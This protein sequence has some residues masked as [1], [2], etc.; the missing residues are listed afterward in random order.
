MLLLVPILVAHDFRRQ[1]H[2]RLGPVRW[3]V[4]GQRAE[5]KIVLKH[6][7]RY[8]S[9]LTTFRLGESV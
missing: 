4:I 7:A 5:I 8:V 2:G 9:W 1:S 6:T 3:I